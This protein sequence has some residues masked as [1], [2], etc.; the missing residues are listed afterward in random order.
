MAQTLSPPA[1]AGRG[2]I[3]QILP[4][5][6]CSTCGRPVPIADLGEHVCSAPPP[7]PAAS[8]KPPMSPTSPSF[9][10]QKYQNLISAN[11]PPPTP[12][13][14]PTPPPPTAARPTRL[15]SASTAS[16]SSHSPL[17]PSS[18]NGSYRSLSPRAPSPSSRVQSPLARTTS[19]AS[20][21]SSNLPRP[22][23]VS[24][25]NPQHNMSDAT[26]IAFPTSTPGPMD[27]TARTPS[28]LSPSRHHPSE[29]TRVAT[30]LSLSN[31][32]SSEPA[33]FMSYD[34]MRVPAVARTPS[35]A[36]ASIPQG[37]QQRPPVNVQPLARPRA[38]S[39][40]S[41]RSASGPMMGVRHPVQSSPAPFLPTAG[42]STLVG[43]PQRPRAATDLANGSPI[44]PPMDLN[45]DIIY[46]TTHR[47]M[48]PPS[49]MRGPP[50]HLNLQPPSTHERSGPNS[51][52]EDIDTK[53]GG[54][55]GMAGVGRRGFAA[56]ARAAM[57]THQ[58]GGYHGEHAPTNTE[59]PGMDRRRANAPR[60]LDIASAN[61]YSASTPPLSPGSTASPR[62]PY[63]Q[64]S[65]LSTSGPISPLRDAPKSVN[66][67]Q[68]GTVARTPSPL[69]R[70]GIPR[71]RSLPPATEPPKVPLPATPSTPSM[72][73]FEKFKN[74]A[75][76]VEPTPE[77]S[78][79]S[80]PLSTPLSPAESEFEGLAYADSSE[81]E[82][83]DLVVNEKTVS[84]N[85]P[86]NRVR[87]PSMSS[88]TNSIAQSESKYSSGSG[89]P[90]VQ[91]LR[92]RSLS[93][94]TARSS[95]T[96]AKRA[97]LKQPLGLD[98]AMETLLEEEATSPTTSSVSSPAMFPL[99]L[100]PVDGTQ[101]DSLSR[102]KLPAR[103]NTSPAS[104][105][106]ESR[107]GGGAKRRATEKVRKVRTCLKCEKGIE[108]GRWIQMEGA[109]VMCDRCWKNMYLPKC[110]RCNLTIEKQAVSSSDG[111]LKGKYHKDCF[112]CHTCH[113]PFPDKSF[114]V[115]DG[116]PY[117][118]Y[119]YHETNNSLCA[120]TLCGQPIEG[121]C[122][123]A[124]NGDRYHPEHL[125][126]DHPRC[127]EKLA[128]YWE[129]DG[130]MFCDRHAQGID[131]DD[132][133]DGYYHLAKQ[134]DSMQLRATKRRT[135]FIDLASLGQGS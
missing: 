84:Q 74:K 4:A 65:P 129:V 72:P 78:P 37:Q 99:P 82:E 104:S 116:K 17:S 28:P 50:L 123:V 126:C 21:V 98:R 10:Q 46:S 95:Y 62:S 71:E 32:T 128:D 132:E 67:I 75:A 69:E 80:P 91:P 30:P 100:V 124:H 121:P 9:F 81:D 57:F 89:S 66:S 79:S 130:R 131:E 48:P 120:A 7:M 58:I 42:P 112:N 14:S 31:R 92:L 61:H 15:S 76:P 27:P 41:T 3:S 111:Q 44:S 87:F 127:S 105:R 38:P 94:S 26:K 103:S 35:P 86:P 6:K 63:S 55:A 54:E 16:R 133:D 108:D 85:S 12:Q 118:E 11:R 47:P 90:S 13:S 93:A 68:S 96:A 113:K 1:P 64:H 117:C 70:G 29:P 2:R 19:P 115:F 39:S 52:A 8:A 43:P 109:G 24:S 110:R 60:F 20:P 97:T 45:P 107:H 33:P 119:H 101:R 51:P 56:A 135:Q 88:K 25:S 22:D 114:Y 18:H 122:A 36:V 23:P 53:I 125:V 59:Y 77:P 40:A 34:A 134:R 73:F 106:P 5:V 83:D 49:P 102:P